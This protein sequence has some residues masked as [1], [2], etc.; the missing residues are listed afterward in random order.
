MTTGS[1]EPA[2]PAGGKR[3]SVARLLEAIVAS[4]PA[5]VPELA[6][7]LGADPAHLDECRDGRRAMPPELQMQLAALVVSLLPEHARPARRLY[8]QA[9][10]A[11]RVEASAGERHQ[12][13]PKEFYR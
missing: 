4:A 2:R 12:I 1:S 5:M 7:L 8:A 10:A 11:L 9:Q 6:R 3:T 13:Y